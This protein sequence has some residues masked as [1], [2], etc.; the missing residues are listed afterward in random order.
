[1]KHSFT[2]LLTLGMAIALH[3]GFASAEFLF[4]EEAP[5]RYSDTKAKDPIAGLI[6]DY[7]AGELAL[8]RSGEL[9]FLRSVLKLLDIPEESQVLVFSRT[10]FQNDRIRPQTPR[11]I[12]FSP[13][14][15]LGWVQG[16]E[17]EIISVDPDLGPVFYRMSTPFGRHPEPRLFRDS[18]CLNCHGSSRTDGYPGMLVRSVYPDDIGS[19]ILGAGTRRT[20][21][22][23]P[24]EERWGGWFVTGDK[25]GDR[26][27]GNIY[28]EEGEP[29]EARPKFDFGAHPSSLESAFDTTKYL[30][31]TSDIV[32]LMAMEHQITAHNAITKA[33]LDTRRWLYLDARI[34]KETG[35]AEGEVGESTLGLIDRGADDLLEVML[36]K[37]EAELVD[38]GVEGG[39]AFQD[40]FV[41]AGVQT[42]DGSSLREFQ[43][44][45]RLFKYRLSYMIYSSS[46][47][48]LH[49]RMKAKFYEKL[50][51]ALNGQ[52]ESS[53]HL[54]EKE[55]SR[56]LEIVMETKDDL[57]GYWRTGGTN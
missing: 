39:D 15:Y 55:R 23:S 13:D 47:E 32:A 28:Y 12:Y 21:H 34:G 4:Y 2:H 30:A 37:D 35:R 10:S 18:Q 57:P 43:L 20:D 40:A 19:P 24:L 8:D 42:A 5:I 27:L 33:H 56:I 38:W 25:A 3:P 51:L 48:H 14:Y 54:S 52:T 7:E 49:P 1:M 16:G 17:I 6:G 36:M 26:H 53:S 46:F 29:G 45:S 44:L 50:H 11:A 9:A 41:A 22:T 31:A